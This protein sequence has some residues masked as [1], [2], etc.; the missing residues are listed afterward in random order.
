[1]KPVVDV[2][3]SFR[4]PYSYLVTPELLALR[5]DFDVEVKLRAVLPIAIRTKGTLFTADNPNKV[6]YI[7]LDAFRRAEYLAMPMVFPTPDPIVQDMTSFV[8][9]EDQPYIYRLTAL[10]IEAE[11]R[12]KGIDFAHAVSRLIWGGSP[13]WDQGEKLSNAVASVGLNLDDMETAVAQ[14]DYLAEIENNQKMLD[15]AGHWGVPTMVF[16]DEPFFG[17]DRVDTLRWRLDQHDLRR[18]NSA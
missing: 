3:F 11:R 6:N 8:V 15:D 1:M 12:G 7:L 17:Q 4:S 13:N 16:N 5:K 18:T 10:A 9:S 14:Y 2:F